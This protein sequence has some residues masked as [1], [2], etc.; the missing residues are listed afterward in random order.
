[1]RCPSIRHAAKGCLC[2]AGCAGPAVTLNFD[3]PIFNGQLAPTTATPVTLT[4]PFTYHGLSFTALQGAS[5]GLYNAAMSR[6]NAGASLAGDSNSAPD[7]LVSKGGGFTITTSTGALQVISL[8]Y[9]APNLVGGAAFTSIAG[10]AATAAVPG[11]G[12]TN[13]FSGSETGVPVQ[14]ATGACVIDT[15][16]FTTGYAAGIDSLV[17]CTAATPGTSDLTATPFPPQNL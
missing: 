9:S 4:S 17:V 11:C 6:D 16:G 14:Y 2:H 15:L 7:F 13:F 10:R 3:D 5:F 1:M 12:Q 8:F